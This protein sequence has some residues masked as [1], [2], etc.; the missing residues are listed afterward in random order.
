MLFVSEEEET[1]TPTSQLTLP[2]QSSASTN[3][4]TSPERQVLNTQP[5]PCSGQGRIRTA[6]AARQQIYS[7]PV[8]TTYLP[9]HKGVENVCGRWRIRTADPLLVR[10]MLWTSW[11]KR[12]F[13]LGLLSESGCKGTHNILHNTHFFNKNVSQYRFS[14][15]I[16]SKTDVYLYKKSKKNLHLWY[17]AG[18]YALSSSRCMTCSRSY[19][20]NAGIPNRTGEITILVTFVDTL[21][22]LCWHFVVTLL[23]LF[24][25]FPSKCQRL[26][27]NI[28]NTLQDFVDT[29]TLFLHC[30]KKICTIFLWKL[31]FCNV[32]R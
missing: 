4:A 27:Y 13:F 29:L 22:S 2:P 17:F 12:P 21:L 28:F 24:D 14:W 6:E 23:T 7:L 26:I 1:R 32:I 18:F 10:Q 5:F 30:S 20:D 16:A 31:C 25:V 8:L 9:T 11:A 3:S 19:H 15:F